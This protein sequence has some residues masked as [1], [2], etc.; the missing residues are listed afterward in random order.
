MSLMFFFFLTQDHVTKKA[1]RGL[2]NFGST[3]VGLVLILQLFND[4]INT[5]D[6]I[7]CDFFF[8]LPPIK[9]AEKIRNDADVCTADIFTADIC[10]ADVCFPSVIVSNSVTSH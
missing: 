2:P 1:Y 8:L 10:P 9:P 3:N 5:A 7:F 6:H 4:E